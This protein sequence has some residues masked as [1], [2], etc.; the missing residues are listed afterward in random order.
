MI[1]EFTEAAYVKTITTMFSGVAVDEGM[2]D[3]AA[4][5]PTGVPDDLRASLER[6]GTASRPDG[7]AEWLSDQLAPHRS[8]VAVL[9]LSLSDMG[10]EISLCLLR[11]KRV[12]RDAHDWNAYEH[13]SAVDLPGEIAE[14]LVEFAN[15]ARA[16]S[17]SSET[18][19]WIVETCV[20]LAWAGLMIGAAMKQL[21]P[22]TLLGDDSRRRVA[23]FFGEGD[24]FF[25][26]EIDTGGF[27]YVEPPAIDAA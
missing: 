3:L 16:R 12:P 4:S 27:R 2:A 25:L 8:G 20:P 1:N 14:P 5:L 10:D 11:E 22:V 23:V 9:W 15:H 19:R 24:D 6:I 17:E 26:G 7:L 21:S 13:I 18:E